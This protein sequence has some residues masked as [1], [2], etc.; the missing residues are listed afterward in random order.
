MDDNYLPPAASLR[1][2]SPA[3]SPIAPGMGRA[4]AA[5]LTVAAVLIG[6]CAAQAGAL[7]MTTLL[8][9]ARIPPEA[10]GLYSCWGLLNSVATALGVA[11]IY[12]AYRRAATGRLTLLAFL[13]LYSGTFRA[14]NLAFAWPFQANVGM[15]IGTGGVGVNLVGVAM[16][17]WW[18]ALKAGE[19]ARAD[20]ADAHA[21]DGHAVDLHREPTPETEIRQTKPTSP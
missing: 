17:V 20:A 4:A 16:I 12:R 6:A 9:G 7:M 13:I 19:A 3:R 2:D 14:N 11:G 21:R 5:F 10:R 15:F 18:F 8:N 1:A